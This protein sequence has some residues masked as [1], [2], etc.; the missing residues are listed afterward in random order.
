MS[1]NCYHLSIKV[2]QRKLQAV[3]SA[4]FAATNGQ[5]VKSS[6]NDKHKLVKRGCRGSRKNR[7]RS[8]QGKV[9]VEKS[10][11]LVNSLAT[12]QVRV[13]RNAVVCPKTYVRKVTSTP[14]VLIP[15]KAPKVPPG[16]VESSGSINAASEQ[17]NN[18]I[19]RSSNSAISS[20][21]DQTISEKQKAVDRSLLITKAINLQ[22]QGIE[23]EIKLLLEKIESH[24]LDIPEKVTIPTFVQS[25]AVTAILNRS[26]T[27]YELAFNRTHNRNEQDRAKQ[28]VVKEYKEH[29]DKFNPIKIDYLNKL[30][31]H[32][33]Q[34]VINSSLLNSLHSKLRDISLCKSYRVEQRQDIRKETAI[35]EKKQQFNDVKIIREIKK[36]MRPIMRNPRHA[37][38]PKPP[39]IEEYCSDD[40]EPPSY[41]GESIDTNLGNLH[42][43]YSKQGGERYTDE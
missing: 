13:V 36:Q 18:I 41:W 28:Q 39:L 25:E 11:I 5:H 34:E 38:A 37:L 16:F 8:R 27:A 20:R 35:L 24:K 9:L 21:L 14:L 4:V 1:G 29:F 26:Y 43:E 31:L 17:L 12:N 2:P 6:T 42:L 30:K 3:L 33:E 23:S 7:E 22:K 10:S 40:D 19:K 32:K 15:S